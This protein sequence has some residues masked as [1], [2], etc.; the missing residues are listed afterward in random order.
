M[1]ANKYSAGLMSQSFWFIELKKTVKLISDGKTDDEVKAMCL[2]DNLY[3]AAKDYRA[4][5]MY[6]YIINR[7]RTLDN[8]MLNLFISSDLATQ[9][10][11]AL[12]S[13]LK[14]DRLFFDFVFEVY[15]EKIILGIPF[16][17]DSDVR[18]FF[19]NKEE[20]SEDVEKWNESTKVKLKNCYLNFMTDANL[21]S[22]CEKQHQIT[23]PILDVALE[24]YLNC[25]GESNLIKAITGVD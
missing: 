23:P 10:I 9:K 13:I 25:C 19:K 14:T 12:I 21:L 1:V 11:I 5:R 6:G 22:D 18:I 4:K 15:R 17:E 20:Q 3:G 16:L 2:D 7:V 24:R 8:E